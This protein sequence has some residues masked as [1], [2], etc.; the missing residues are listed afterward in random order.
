[1]DHVRTVLGGFTFA[2]LVF[3]YLSGEL[4]VDFMYWVRNIFGV[5]FVALVFA[6]VW[7]KDFNHKMIALAF[8][9]VAVIMGLCWALTNTSFSTLMPTWFT[10]E[11]TQI[12]VGGCALVLTIIWAFGAEEE[13]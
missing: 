7:P 10:R 3:G 13:S 12:A 6:M 9:A 8:F 4:P 2:A 11:S 1:M 5:L